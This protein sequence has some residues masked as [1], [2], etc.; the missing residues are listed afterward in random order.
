MKR[1]LFAAAMATTLA[2][3]SP[4]SAADP[5][6]SS[7]VRDTGYVEGRWQDGNQFVGFYIAYERLTQLEPAVNPGPIFPITVDPNN[8]PAAPASAVSESVT[9]QGAGLFYCDFDLGVCD[10]EFISPGTPNDGLITLEDSPL[11]GNAMNVVAEVDLSGVTVSIDARLARPGTT[12]LWTD[13]TILH[14]N[15]WQDGNT[16][17]AKPE[18]IQPILTRHTYQMEGTGS[19]NGNSLT[20]AFGYAYFSRDLHVNAS[21]EAELP[22]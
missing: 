21:A 18:V 12:R 5:S 8:P 6:A 4:A 11:P 20:P 16:L 2:L 13:N 1:Y 3:A 17:S 15:V 22:A 19:L 7:K 14:P 10:Q 9:I